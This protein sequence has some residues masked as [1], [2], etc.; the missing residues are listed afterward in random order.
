MQINMLAFERKVVNI[1]T[2]QHLLLSICN[3][4]INKYLSIRL[5]LVWK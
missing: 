4:M 2:N 3:I 5:A 1:F